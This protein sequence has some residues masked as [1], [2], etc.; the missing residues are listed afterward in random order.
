MMSVLFVLS[1]YFSQVDICPYLAFNLSCLL[2]AM[3]ERGGFH[4]FFHD[5][6][7]WNPCPS[8]FFGRVAALARG[9]A[10][11]FCLES[12]TLSLFWAR[13]SVGAW[14]VLRILFGI[15]DPL[16]VFAAWQSWRVKRPE[17]SAC[18]R[19]PSRC[20]RRAA[21]LARGASYEFCL[22]SLT[23]SL[24]STRGSAGAWSVPRILRLFP[25]SCP[26]FILTRGLFPDSC[27]LFFLTR[28]FC[29]S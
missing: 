28:A 14:S 25:D 26:C 3:K 1:S 2:I 24:F 15:G 19:C 11:E 12:L 7:T 8:R 18:N 21:A 5:V 27:L 6:C 10:Y 22:E 29:F 13:G 17:T 4:S 16:A 23:P 20:F 9:A